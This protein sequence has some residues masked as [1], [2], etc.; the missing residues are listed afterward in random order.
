MPSLC[1]NA[2][3]GCRPALRLQR[4]PV[5]GNGRCM[6]LVPLVDALRKAALPAIWSRGVSLA[7]SSQ[8]GLEARGQK[9]I[10]LKVRTP[11]RAAALGVTLYP[12]DAEWS[13]EC[14]SRVDPCEHVVG[15][16]L[17]LQQN[18]KDGAAPVVP[19]KQWSRVLYRFTRVK[20]GLELARF[21]AH[22]DGTETLLTEPL[23]ALVARPADA[24]KLQ[25]EQWDLTADRL[26]EKPRRGPVSTERLDALLKILEPSRTVLLDGRPVA[27]AEEPVLPSAVV[28]EHRGEFRVVT[29]RDPSVTDVVSAGVVLCG[30]ALCRMGETA[31]SGLWMEKLPAVRTF[32]AEQVGDLITQVLPTLAQRIPVDVR[33][34]KLPSVDRDLKPRMVMEL[35]Q[36][37]GG[38]SAL[39]TLVY[40]FPAH[41]RI[42]GARMV[43]LKGSVPL[44][45]ESAEQKLVA[46][47]RDTLNMVPGRRTTV[48]TRD[49]Q[50]FMEKLRK[51]R[52][53]ITGDGAEFL[54]PG[55]KLVPVMQVKQDPNAAIPAVTLQMEF[56]VD[57]VEGGE[58]RTVSAQAVVG[59]WREGLGLVPLDGGGWAPIPREW[60]MRHGA[61]VLELLAARDSEGKV[62][63]HALPALSALCEALDEPVPAG[64]ERL[65]PL[66]EGFDRLPAADLPTDLHAT[67]RPYQLEGV[68][69]LQFLQR[70]GLGG[71][72]ADDMGLGK[73]LQTL[74]VLGGRCL[75]VCPASVLPNWAAE[76]AKFRPS[77]KVSTYH[78]PGRALDPAANLTLTTYAILRLDAEVLSAQQWDAAILDEAQ[79]IKNPDSKVARA[80]F[81]LR[82]SFRLALSGTPVENRLTDLWSLMHFANRGLLGGRRDFEDN[83][84]RPILEGRKD[85]TES[86]R[87]RT[88]PF[89]MRRLKRDVAPDLPPRTEAI[90]HVALDERERTVYDTVRAASQKDVAEL[91]NGGGSI[92]AALEALLRLRQAACHSALI[93]GQEALS[94]SKVETLVDALRT[95]ADEGHKSLVFSQWTSLLDRVEPALK[96]A[97]LEFVR[98]DGST[99]DRGA[100]TARFQAEQG[101]PVMLISLKAGGTGLNLTAAD[102]VFL[103]DPWWNPAVEAQ[104]ADRAHRIGQDK[105]VMVYRLVAQGT[106]EERI[107][108]LQDQKRGLQDA[109]VG[110]GGAASSLTR[111]DLMA[112]LA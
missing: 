94:S 78:G 2:S 88:R 59:A 109:A 11:G 60:L 104:A 107:L 106:V 89:V 7:R 83:V 52:G 101:P 82:A 73:T 28:D 53:A 16:A 111:D 12:L 33:T 103:L 40:G 58:A 75:V 95:A 45:D 48:S 57:G 98:L 23:V 9:D 27:V 84:A 38:V 62:A 108:K 22:P 15:A 3:A 29:D 68:K 43:H 17:W 56:R 4:V 13:C 32:P 14:P 42:D 93:P 20:G 72:L 79:A 90:L 49:L 112:L 18:E 67:L 47:L 55:V 70:G 71:V 81:G 34:Q 105:P 92:M 25:V 1:H 44:R 77:L 26:L 69:W 24:D 76:A 64:L 66:A 87:R 39:P 41:A 99:V 51:W 97:G 96:Q 10:E 8:V 102:H 61:Q 50:G 36:V 19:N 21:L 63:N 35:T 100:V 6:D 5:V 65:R 31:L 86:L 30:D 54:G 80:A 85:A 91:L 37:D 74:S 46:T 110:D